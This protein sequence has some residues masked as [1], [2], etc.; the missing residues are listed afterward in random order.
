MPTLTN[1]FRWFVPRIKV[2]VIEEGDF[3]GNKIWG[4]GEPVLQQ[5]MVRTDAEIEMIKR[6]MNTDVPKEKWVDI[7][8]FHEKERP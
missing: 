1:R 3:A 5:L 8:V 4:D 6:F 2:G 7:E